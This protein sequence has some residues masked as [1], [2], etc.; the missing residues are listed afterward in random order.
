MARNKIYID[1]VVDD[2]GTTRRVAVDSD[3]LSQSLGR[4]ATQS[5]QADR[6]IKGVAQASSNAT[7]NFSKMSQGMGGLVAAYATV[8]AQVF[9]LSA[10][11][12]FLLEASDFT[13]LLKGQ[14]A[15]T[16]T[17]GVAYASITKSIQQAT[18]AQL[19]YKEAAQAAAIS[20]AAGLGADQIT[21]I[22]RLS[23][24]ISK[25]L[26]R[27]LTDTFNRL[28]RGITKAEPEL[29]DELGIVLRLRDAQADYAQSIGKSADALTAYERT[30]AV[31]L[32]TVGQGEEK[33]GAL[34]DAL[35]SSSNK[36]RQLGVA[37]SQVADELKPVI[38]AV[39]DFIAGALSENISG[40]IATFGLL[41]GG[42]LRQLL[43]SIKEIGDT[44]KV[45]LD[46]INGRIDT[47]NEKLKQ[48]ATNQRVLA[49][50]LTT[51]AEAAKTA[52]SGVI[53]EARVQ[54]E[55]QGIDPQ[56]I[57]KT[58]QGISAGT[59]APSS[60]AF[61]K[62]RAD[63]EKELLKLEATNQQVVTNMK[64]QFVTMTREQVLA[65]KT[66][67]AIMAND[68]RQL[69]E[70]QQG[71]LTTTQRSSLAIGLFGAR[72]GGFFTR[73]TSSVVTFGL[74][75]LNFA[76]YLGLIITAVQ[77]LS[78]GWN[79]L[80]GYIQGL[81]AEKTL[82]PLSERLTSL[83]EETKSLVQSFESM[84][85]K[86]DSFNLQ[87][88]S[89]QIK[90]FGAAA[91]NISL[92]SVV[93]SFA[94]LQG[95]TNILDTIISKLEE[96]MR[97]QLPIIRSKRLIQ[98]LYTFIWKGSRAE[99]QD[100][101][102][103]DLVMS[104]GIGLWIRDTAIRLKQEGMDLNRKALDYM[105]KYSGNQGTGVYNSRHMGNQNPWTMKTGDGDE[106][107]SWLIK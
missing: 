64:S 22:A 94:K 91:S 19:T 68:M 47:F 39:S 57:S 20:T 84:Q 30:Q 8:A 23:D 74:R 51:E 90:F 95:S 32:F 28:T 86:A 66:A 83:N 17:T 38:S 9:A 41:A 98:E 3:R 54:R 34:G 1:V 62:F 72:I 65:M 96:N 81:N 56:K 85:K 101:Y 2:N 52:F 49:R 82:K 102:N 4:T 24:T 25:T 36:V 15:L 107:I 10:A 42:V 92:D 46:G 14:E 78:E 33:F 103:D 88:I 5:A 27:D 59:I 100:G 7:K 105:I 60:L 61:K 50:G 40:T 71:V 70:V 89:G 58:M 53:S 43:P 29:L 13:I 79:L 77:L 11:Y 106:D 80:T 26:G 18:N 63:V 99:S 104:F 73:A 37:L 44:Y 75:L 55:A 48:S 97:E 31:F 87:N 69:E 76:G 35:G 12:Q 6:N 67:T 93:Q 45:T 16:A 21:R